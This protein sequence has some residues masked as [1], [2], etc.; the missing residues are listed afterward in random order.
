MKK[1]RHIIKLVHWYM[2]AHD[3]NLLLMFLPKI[4][5]QYKRPILPLNVEK[6]EKK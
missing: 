2:K 5:P 3:Y 6:D 1:L 4:K